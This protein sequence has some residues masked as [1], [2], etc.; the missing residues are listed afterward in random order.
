[1]KS[2]LKLIKRFCIT[3]I[4]AVVLLF[5]LNVVLLISV[6]YRQAANGSGWSAAEEVAAGLAKGENGEYALSQEGREVLQSGNAWA[7]L[8][9]NGTGQVVWHS[10]NLPG[11]VP[12]HYTVSDISQA[13]RGYIADYP[14]TAGA[15]GDDLVI[16]GYPGTAYWK[17]MWNTFDYEMIASL[18]R[19][20][21]IIFMANCALVF[22][23]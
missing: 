4:L 20:L 3:L 10:E 5:L 12:L 6:S 14:T 2:T 23:I 9:E 22:L 16:L 15:C 18:P 1:M 8:I 17:L 13:T 7:I 21:L 11:E 19:T